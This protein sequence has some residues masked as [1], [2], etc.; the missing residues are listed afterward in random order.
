MKQYEEH[1]KRGRWSGLKWLSLCI[2]LCCSMGAA[3]QVNKKVTVRLR[4][5]TIRDV[6]AEVKKQAEVGFMYSNTAVNSLPRKDYDMVNVPVTSVIDRSL[7]GSELTYEVDGEK[8]IVIKRIQQKKNVT[9]RVV[10]ADGNPLPGVTVREKDGN[11]GCITDAQGN[12]SMASNKQGLR[13]IVSY[14]G[15]R[16]QELQWKGTPLNIFMED[17][18]S[19]IEEVVITGYQT[20]DPRKNTM[21][22][23]SV[24]MEDVLMPNMTTIDQALEGRIPDLL[25]MQ[26]SGEA[27]ATARLRVRGTST[28]LGNREPLWVLDGFVL[29]DPVDV[30]TD[31]LNDPDYINYVGNAISGINPQDIERIDV[32]KD[33]AATA[34]YGARASNGVIVVTT[35]KGKAGP[36]S[37]NYSNQTKVTMR[38]RYSDNNI[39]LMNSQERVL[40]GKELCD[41]HYVF[42]DNMPMVGYEGEFY[43]YQTGQISYDEFKKNVQWY[44]TANT[45]WFDLLTQ[46]AITHSHTLSISGGSETTRY[47]ASLGYTREN[48]VIKTQYTDRYTASMNVMTTLAKNLKANIRL[49]GNVQKKNHL[50]SEVQVLDYAYETTRALP[51][52]NTDGTYYYYQAHG[53]D[54]GNG[55]KLYNLYNYNILN[56]IDNT[57]SDYSG[58]TLSASLD[59]NYNLKD[60]LTA[61][62]AANYSRSSTLQGTWFGEKTNYV[63]ILKNGELDETPIE[64]DKGYCELPYGGV[65][66]TSNTINE[67]M[68]GRVQLNFRY[69]FN[70]SKHLL[71]ALVGYEVNM[72]RSTGISD[73]TRGYYKDRGMKYM[74][75]TREDLEKYPLYADWLA[76]GHRT[77][78]SGKTNSISGYMTLGYDFMNYFSLGLSGRFDASNKFGSR[79][80]EKFLPVWSVSGRWNIRETFFPETNIISD[81]NTRF[82][83]GKTGNMLDGETPN[84]LIKQGVFDTWYEENV[85][86]VA[87]LP[88]PN[89]RWEETTQTNIGMEVSFLGGRMNLSGD[90]W[91]KH[92]RDA[93]AEVNVSTVNGV[94]S[95]RMNNGDLKGKGYSIYLSGTPLKT[96]DWR[97]YVSGGYSWADNTVRTNVSDNYEIGDYLNG[98]AII[99]GKAIGTFYSYKFLGLN[100]E[101]GVPMFDDYEDRQSLLT[102]KSLEDVVSMV[103][104]ESGSREP[105]F[106]GSLYTTLTYKQLSLNLN[107]VYSLG[108]KIRLFELYTPVVKGVSSDKNVR[109]EFANRWMKPGDEK[110]TNIP[111]LVSQGDANWSSYNNHWSASTSASLGSIPTFASNLWSMY[112]KSDIRV[113][114]GDYLKLN[115][116]AMSYNFKP[117]QLQKT[118]L[119]SCRLSFNV[120]NV[121]TWASSKLNGQDPQQ[122]GFSSV[123]LTS[124]PS[125]TMGLDISF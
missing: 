107:F 65:Y 59:L 99:D 48:G 32:L 31:Q 100:P 124:R 27:G 89:L 91:F 62:V 92:V 96:R 55:N 37:I 49:N 121:F 120:S 17:D 103:M 60:W 117:K 114:P 14:I 57:S 64:G 52:Y 75:M 98:T 30:S 20:I 4:N 86:T 33:A 6:F 2:L 54:V 102:G 66:N 119:K 87:Y 28:I 39:N 40:F 81:W 11:A 7:E 73:Q 25:Y 10:D 36:P 106:T 41:L 110:Y 95:Y 29:Q 34:L 12:F 82:S 56:E 67:N 78:T 84:L 123:N 5:A 125:Y 112:D 16:T 43:R 109:K 3:A 70:N 77:L 104:V 1:V 50:P 113:V 44:E 83:F 108:S 115:N 21:A 79:S 38:P 116:L 111:A 8:T 85:S 22:I 47:Y 46:D 45:D 88:N 94:S 42:P 90:L 80:N 19:E 24:K 69:A 71:S 97:L 18:S 15:M 105:K 58:N 53:Y 61:T 76:E 26:N 74:S 13:L 72:R 35:K 93:F 68:T 51:A 23:S 101:T 122:A 63:A 118:F 9:G